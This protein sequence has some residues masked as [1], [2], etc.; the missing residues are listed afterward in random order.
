MERKKDKR[1]KN[2]RNNKEGKRRKQT[3]RFRT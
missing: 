2:Y 1:A 3:G